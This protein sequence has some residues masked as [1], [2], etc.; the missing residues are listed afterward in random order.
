LD[1]DGDVEIY[2]ANKIVDHD[3][4][5]L[6]TLND[7]VTGWA[8]TTA[9]D[10]DDDGDLEVVLG[11]SAYHHDG[12]ELYKNNS[13]QVGMPQVG[14]LD[15]D[16]LPEVLLANGSGLG[17]TLLE[18]NGTVKYQNVNPTGDFDWRRPIAIHDMDGDEVSEFAVSSNANFGVYEGIDAELKWVM[19]V[20]DSSGLASG[21][22]FD[23]LGDG[24]AEAIYADQTTLFVYDGNDG[25]V[26][27][28]S[29]RS[30]GTLTEYPAVSDVD[31]DGSAE[32][33][34][35]SNHWQQQFDPMVQAIRDVEDRW[36]QARRIWNQHTYHVTNVREDATIPQNEAQHWTQLNTFRTNAQIEG[37]AVCEPPQ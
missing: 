5:L 1:T 18:H 33:I 8:A 27:L 19:P 16:G 13:V 17:L 14:D 25:T 20:D 36:I 2:F 7:Q 3:G 24:I 29:P 31:N 11:R 34:V 4:N 15:D 32:I 10:L 30:S 28:Q 22:A 26:L 12:A 37:G 23:F 21:T 6:E 9:A 35:V